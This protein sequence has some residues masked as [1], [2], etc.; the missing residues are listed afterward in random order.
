MFELH[1]YPE[2][3]LP[4]LESLLHEGYTLWHV[5]EGR[6]ANGT[7]GFDMTICMYLHRNGR[8]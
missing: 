8:G 5:E 7:A 4:L 6:Y 3:W 2:R 1:G